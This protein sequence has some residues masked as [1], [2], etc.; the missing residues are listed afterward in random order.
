MQ[1]VNRILWRLPSVIH[2]LIYRRTGWVLVRTSRAGT[3]TF[4]W[5]PYDEVAGPHVVE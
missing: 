2:E 3:V 5:K 4:E 1:R